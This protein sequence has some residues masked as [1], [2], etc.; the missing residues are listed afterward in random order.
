M[1]IE[2][3]LRET[4]SAMLWVVPTTTAAIPQRMYNLFALKMQSEDE[5]VA[6]QTSCGDRGPEYFWTLAPREAQNLHIL[7]PVV[8]WI[9]WVSLQRKF[10]TG[11]HI[12]LAKVLNHF[13][14]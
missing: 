13:S 5:E 2:L 10:H 1:V 7:L 8:M 4:C 14:L 3:Y 9:R 11:F 6:S 12:I